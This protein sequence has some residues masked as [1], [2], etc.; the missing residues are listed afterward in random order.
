MKILMLCYEYPPIGGG[1]AIYVKLIS[2]ELVKQGHSV[3]VVTMQY[4]DRKK[5][6]H[7]QLPSQEADSGVAIYRVPCLRKKVEVC[8]TIEMMTYC[9]SAYW[10]CSKLIKKAKE[11]G[12]PYDINHT[13]FIIPTGL[14]S[15]FLKRKH[16]LPYV[17]TMHG[18]D[19]PGYN[20]DRFQLQHKLLR[21]FWKVLAKDP[22]FVTCHTRALGQLILKSQPKADVVIIPNAVDPAYFKTVEK[23]KKILLSSRLLPRKGIQHFLEAIADMD[24]KGFEVNITGDGPYRQELEQ[25]LS[26]LKQEGKI[27]G[28]VTL[29]GWVPKAFLNQLYEESLIFVFPS[30]M[31][32]FSMALLDAMNARMAIIAANCAGNPEATGDTAILVPGG[33]IGALRTALQKLIKDK[34]LC[35]EYGEKAKQRALENFTWK[36]TLRQYEEIFKKAGNINAAE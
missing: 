29:R 33:D 9:W 23:K 19:V 34:Q 25:Q 16:G 36:K 32:N 21:P 18:S 26:R 28:K 17:V 12:Q 27:K 15:Y 20:P 3:D 35:Q 31:D 4:H 1:A 30:V 6:D 14:V 5:Q 22:P 2:K 8:T 7:E 13:H 10:F 11:A 24:L